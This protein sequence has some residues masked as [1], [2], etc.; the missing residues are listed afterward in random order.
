MVNIFR[1]LD[2]TVL[3]DLALSVIPIL[4]CIT[5]HECCHGL[6]ALALGDDTAKRAGRLSL[7]PIKHFDAVGFIMML[8]VHFGWAKPVPVDMRRFKNPKLGMAVTALAGPVSNILLAILM[9][10]IYGLLYGALVE[11]TVGLYVLYAIRL[12]ATLSVS[13]GI[14]NLIPVPPLDG[15]KVLFAFLPQR[16]YYT[17]MRYEKYGSLVMIVLVL[18]GVLTKPLSAAVNWVFGG[19]MVFAR[20]G[21]A[22]AGLF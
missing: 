1:N 21:L 7:N 19:L 20:L 11:T 8:V 16:W 15:S 4:I 10:F 18:T 17:L 6:C 9:L 14:F 3:L 12:T 5:V 22:L 13:L 2:W